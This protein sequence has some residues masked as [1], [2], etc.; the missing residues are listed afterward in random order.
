[1]SHVDIKHNPQ[2][3]GHNIK[4]KHNNRGLGVGKWSESHVRKC[5]AM[6]FLKE[7][8]WEE[9]RCDFDH[10]LQ[11][12]SGNG[13]KKTYV[14]RPTSRCIGFVK[15]MFFHS[16]I[17]MKCL[18]IVFFFL[19]VNSSVNAARSSLNHVYR[20]KFHGKGIKFIKTFRLGY[21]ISLN[22]V[23]VKSNSDVLT[24]LGSSSAQ[25][26]FF[27]FFL[28]FFFVFVFFVFILFCCFSI[29]M[30]LNNGCY[31]KKCNW[32]NSKKSILYSREKIVY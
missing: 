23:V 1:M 21:V 22:V 16:F 9:N 6:L 14:L 28:S 29:N 25:Y 20:R 19:T 2:P 8:V 3:S 17:A 10:K 26:L 5:R 4:E 30:Y 11:N 31:V 15:H 32:I 24:V 7:P 12:N 13:D 27:S 18:H